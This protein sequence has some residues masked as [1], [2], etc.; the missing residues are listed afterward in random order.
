MLE[1]TINILIE[2]SQLQP[3]VKDGR[4]FTISLKAKKLIEAIQKRL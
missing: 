3:Y 1:E 4:D 2:A